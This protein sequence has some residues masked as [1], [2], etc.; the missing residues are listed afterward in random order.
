MRL[1]VITRNIALLMLPFLLMIIINEALRPTIKEKPFSQNNIIAINSALKLE[2]KC[3]W[4]CHNVE[5]YCRNHHVKILKNYLHI[6]D[7]IYF[8]TI[9][10]LLSTGKYKTANVA[11]LVIFIPLLMYLLLI[12]SLSLQREIKKAKVSKMSGLF[13][14]FMGNMVT[15]VYFY[16]TNFIINLANL[17][18]LSYYE[19]NFFIFC[20]IYPFLLFSLLLIFVVQRVRLVRKLQ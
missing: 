18:G 14:L 17:L 16:C 10:L 1:F 9:Q 8:G 7:P 5:N 12:K 2:N 20:V 15:Q 19:I 11:I 4:A 3:S 6:S 13:L